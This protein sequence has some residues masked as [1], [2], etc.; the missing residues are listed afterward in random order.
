MIEKEIIALLGGTQL[1]VKFLGPA[2]EY[3]GNELKEWSEKRLRNL[4]S[5]FVKAINQ[6][7]LS[8]NDD[9]KISPRVLK[10]VIS[11]GS[12]QE[13]NIAQEYYAGILASARTNIERD[14]RAAI[15]MKLISQLTTYQILGHYITYHAVRK[16]YAGEDYSFTRKKDRDK[17]HTFIDWNDFYEMIGFNQFEN[18]EILIPHIFFGL[19]KYE[20]IE[21]F[22]Y[23]NKK[24]VKTEPDGNHR[25]GIIVIPSAI[26][27][28]LFLSVYNKPNL[29]TSDLLSSTYEFKEM[30]GINIDRKFLKV[31]KL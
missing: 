22:S 19:R 21:D 8:E 14:D 4:N 23:G 13:D 25:P 16:V 7:E 18:P 2:A 26:G 11:E 20:L 31:V 24:G 9:R 10:E 27:A 29:R 6:T 28:E 1:I 30:E 17:M 5:I 12:V 3:L 15:T